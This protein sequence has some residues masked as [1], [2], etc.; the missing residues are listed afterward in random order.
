M[1]TV[2][3]ILREFGLDDIENAHIVNGHVPVELKKGDSPVLCGGKLFIIDGGFS[4]AYQSKT[5]IAGYTLVYNS[6]GLRLVA[7]EPFTSAEDAIRNETDIVSD[8][9]I[10]ESKAER[11]LVK[12]TDIGRKIREQI[13]E[14]T[15]L[16][17]AYEDGSIAELE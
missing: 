15:V 8:S 6:H 1:D 4:K 17:T 2:D 7:H 9:E 11:I 3:A 14:L 16:L 10:I 13:A 12:D 5:G